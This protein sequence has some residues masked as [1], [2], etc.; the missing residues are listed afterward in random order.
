MLRVA[1]IIF[2]SL[3]AFTCGMLPAIRGD[4][5][6]SPSGL[7]HLP[8]YPKGLLLSFSIVLFLL[9][10]LLVDVWVVY[11]CF[12]GLGTCLWPKGQQIW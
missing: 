1:A 11:L 7:S 3:E 5:L 9:L 10:L 2:F 4:N 12:L 6:E 8:D